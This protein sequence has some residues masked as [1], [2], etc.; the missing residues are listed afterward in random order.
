MAYPITLMGNLLNNG[1]KERG[2]IVGERSRFWLLRDETANLLNSFYLFIYFFK[3]FNSVYVN[4]IETNEKSR[5]YHILHLLCQ[6]KNVIIL[7]FT[8]TNASFAIIHIIWVV[9]VYTIRNVKQ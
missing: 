8:C 1:E 9:G 4:E 7:I 2:D 5:E 6:L 3:F